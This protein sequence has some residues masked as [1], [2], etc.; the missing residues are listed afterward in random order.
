MRGASYAG[1]HEMARNQI[2]SNEADVEFRLI[3]EFGK[4]FTAR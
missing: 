2:V 4:S 1:Q 3:L